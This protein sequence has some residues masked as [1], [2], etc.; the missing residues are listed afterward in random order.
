[1]LLI[2]R[3]PTIEARLSRTVYSKPN[4]QIRPARVIR[5]GLQKC[6]ECHGRPTLIIGVGA[7]LTGFQ[8]IGKP[9][10]HLENCRQKGKF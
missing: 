2:R 9:Y 6:I 10:I 4:W 5:E 1:M 3:K 8:E 7:R